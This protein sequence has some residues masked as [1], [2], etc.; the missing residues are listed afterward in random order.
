M[1]CIFYYIGNRVDYPVAI[2]RSSNNFLQKLAKV[3][4]YIE[5][6]TQHHDVVGEIS[7][8]V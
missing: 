8:N 7:D 4:T 3:S 6:Y 5:A 2:T 1:Q